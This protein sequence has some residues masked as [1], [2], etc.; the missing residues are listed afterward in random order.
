MWIP[1][2]SGKTKQKKVIINELVFWRVVKIVFF[3]E[4][5]DVPGHSVHYWSTF[6]LRKGVFSNVLILST[7]Q[8][9][10][11]RVYLSLGA[12]QGIFGSLVKRVLP[13]CCATRTRLI[14]A[15]K[16]SDWGHVSVWLRWTWR[17]HVQTSQAELIT[18]ISLRLKPLSVLPLSPMSCSF[19]FYVTFVMAADRLFIICLYYSGDIIIHFHW[20][21]KIMCILAGPV[22]FFKTNCCTNVK[23]KVKCSG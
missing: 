20:T 17:T 7:F 23:R 14:T 5:L 3:G 15:H 6:M 9:S 10:D 11:C 19:L 1:V 12:E 21:L 4:I 2:W 16:W 8:K 13:L 18:L 22:L